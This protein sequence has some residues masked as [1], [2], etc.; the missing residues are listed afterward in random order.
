MDVTHYRGDSL[1]IKVRFQSQGVPVDV[2]EWTFAAYIKDS[3]AG[4]LITEFV[5]LTQEVY[6]A[7]PVNGIIRLWLPFEAARLLPATAVWDL[8]ATQWNKGVPLR[9]QTVLRGYVYTP[10][11]VTYPISP[12]V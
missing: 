6:G 5:P 2:S 12:G 9:V 3:V 4:A 1:A 10:A 7:D 11:D 8:E